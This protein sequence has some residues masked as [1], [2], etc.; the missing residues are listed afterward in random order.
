MATT[1]SQHE[2]IQRLTREIMQLKEKLKDAQSN[3]PHEEVRDYTFKTP[4]GEVKLSELFGDRPDL[5]V[6][7]NMGKGCVYCTLWADGINGLVKPIEDRAALVVISPNPPAVQSDFA[8]SR[9]WKFRMAS[10]E[11]DSFTGDMGF[12]N[13]SDGYWPGVSAFKKTEDGK[14]YR[15]GYAVFGPNDDF[16]AVWPMFDLLADGVNNW[17]PKYDYSATK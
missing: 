12:W 4:E 17:E 1:T 9:G 7:H 6:I 2:E 16:C 11:G 5:L 8:A 13:E 3:F 14:I 10:S 15:T